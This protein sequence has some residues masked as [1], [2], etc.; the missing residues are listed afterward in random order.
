MI[1]QEK[2]IYL[3]NQKRHPHTNPRPELPKGDFS[4]AKSSFFG[5]KEAI[6]GRM[7][8]EE[9]LKRAYLLCLE[10]EHERSSWGYDRSK[11][12][13]IAQRDL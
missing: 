13:M 9:T 8:F 12:F 4:R 1:D 6:H 5:L 11:N 7:A 2:R 10:S 3:H